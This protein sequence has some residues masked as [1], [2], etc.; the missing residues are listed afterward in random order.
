MVGGVIL[1]GYLAYDDNITDKRP[2]ILVVHEWW[3][4]NEYARRRARM[5][6]ELGYVALA[7]DMYGGGKQ[8]MHPKEAGEFAN[9]IQKNMVVGRTRF[10]AAIEA[11]KQQER[12]DATKIAAV[13]YCF[14]GG[15]VLEM[16]RQGIELTGVVSFHG[17]LSTESPAQPNTV[18]AKILVL[19]GEADAM[20]MPEQVRAF[21]DEMK[22]AQV[23]L[24]FVSYP[25]VQHS[26]TNPDADIYAKN[27]GL[28]VAYNEAADRDSWN[29]LQNFLKQIFAVE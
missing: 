4:H 18:K 23:N 9:E 15:I 22:A 13:G 11:L 29:K 8:A 21:K 12:V 27:F 25:G 6:A 10:I 26:F 28:P 3:G 5:L 2:G 20:V 1:K 24:D 17:G 16:A 14:G 19:H 7:V